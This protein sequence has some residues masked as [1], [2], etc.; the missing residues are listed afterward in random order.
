MDAAAQLEALL[1]D[2]ASVSFAEPD[3]GVARPSSPGLADPLSRVGG[4]HGGLGLSQKIEIQG[5][6]RSPSSKLYSSVCINVDNPTL[7]FGVIESATISLCVRKCDECKFKGHVDRK[8]E[9][10]DGEEGDIMFI[11]REQGDEVNSVFLTRIEKSKVAPAVLRDWESKAR[12][13][14]EWII[15]FHAVDSTDF[16]FVTV[17]D[18][19]EESSLILNSGEFRTPMKKRMEDPTEEED[20]MLGEISFGTYDLTL[21]ADDSPEMS[22]VIAKRLLEPGTL[23]RVVGRIMTPMWK[24]VD[25]IET[26]CQR[27]ALESTNDLMMK[28]LTTVTNKVKTASEQIF[29]LKAKMQKMEQD[30]DKANRKIESQAESL[31]KK[32]VSP[33]GSNVM[34]DLISMLGGGEK[35]VSEDPFITPEKGRDGRSESSSTENFESQMKMEIAM[36]V[37]EVGLL[38]K[39]VEDTSVKFGGL[40]LRSIQ[41]CHEWIQSKFSGYRYGLIMDPL[42]ML[43]RVFGS[44][45]S[46]LGDGQQ[47]KTLEYRIKFKITRTEAEAAAIKALYYKRPR[48]FHKGRINMATE[49]NKSKLNKIGDYKFGKREEK[50]SRTIS[51]SK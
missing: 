6:K 41:A 50:E 51:F 35:V 1:R 39:S 40:D 11:A 43:D 38:K 36:L 21:P 24:K 32:D 22:D 15:D 49:R 10:M 42:L 14:E 26:E 33:K 23:T 27:M 2:T 8:F 18:I 4:G 29:D 13:L 17:K 7:C 37:A 47:F 25:Y 3:A 20:F 9:F 30:L 34:D 31:E 48:I 5:T 28:V 44:D 16:V 12:T 45:D 46:E 19:K